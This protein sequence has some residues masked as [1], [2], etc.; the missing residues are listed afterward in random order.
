[1]KKWA[2]LLTITCPAVF[3]LGVQDISGN[4]D[5]E[6]QFSGDYPAQNRRESVPLGQIQK[7]FSKAKHTAG[8]RMLRHVPD[9]RVDLVVREGMTTL[10]EFAS[11]ERVTPDG[12]DMGDPGVFHARV[13]KPNVI[14]VRCTEI[15]VD[16]SMNVVGESGHIYVF[17]LISHG[18]NS[19]TVP[20]MRVQV[21]AAFPK[22][23]MIDGRYRSPIDTPTAKQE[24]AHTHLKTIDGGQALDFD[25]SMYGAK[26]IAPLRV[27]N[28]GRFTY[29]DYGK[30]AS[31]IGEVVMSYIIDGVEVPVDRFLQDKKGRTVVNHVGDFHL[32]KGDK[33]VC[34]KY[35]QGDLK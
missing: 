22:Y 34:V 9:Q 18:D 21:R 16:T 31:R 1:M 17:R 2:L 10:I 3:A 8:I 32:K 27:W 33:S 26:E 30:R 11:F 24:K 35:K 28:D 25:Y 23:P 7:V 15:G 12:I 6:R 4:V 13:L 14:S 5:V 29:F 19:K 20:D